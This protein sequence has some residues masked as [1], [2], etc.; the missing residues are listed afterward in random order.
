MPR[1]IAILVYWAF[2]LFPLW[3]GCQTVPATA[4][5]KYL[6]SVG[7]IEYDSTLDKRDFYLCNKA[8]IFQY[9]NNELALEYKGEKIALDSVF[10]EKYVTPAGATGSG[11]IRIR[12]V[13]NCKGETDRFRVI[14]M[15]EQYRETQFDN[16]V[17]QQLLAICK[18]LDGWIPKKYQGKE[19]DFYQYLIFKIKEGQLIE[20][21]P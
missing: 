21:M 1:T 17:V 11:L 9:H 16:R 3:V 7:D 14:A 18:S 4:K 2:I 12:F 19:I 5:S 6:N 10:R 13:V 15:D 20:I 8:D